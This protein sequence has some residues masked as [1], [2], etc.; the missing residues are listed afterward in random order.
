MSVRGDWHA[1]P[2]AD[3]VARLGSDTALGLSGQEARRRLVTYG[4]NTLPVPAGAS[5][6][7]RLWSQ[8]NDFLIL[9]LAVAAS[10]SA[11]VG[12]PV[13]A[14]VILG[15][16]VIN[17]AL[18]LYQESKA[19]HALAHLQDLAPPVA[20][21][22]RNGELQEIAAASLVPG[23]LVLV[24]SGD[25]VPADLR[26]IET[27]NL[28]VNEAPL[29]GEAMAVEK[30]AEALP[31]LAAPLGE[32]VNMAYMGTTVVY[33]RGRGVVVSTGQQS[34]IGTITSQLAEG[35]L[36]RTHLQ[37]KLAELGHWLG[38]VTLAV[39]GVVFIAGVFQHRPLLH[40]FLTAVSL[41]VAA[42]PEG[43]PAVITV[44][45]AIG[46]QRMAA[47]HAV[48][49]R[50]GA[51]EA[52]GAVTLIASDKTG[53]LTENTMAAVRLWLPGRVVE[54]PAG[55]NSQGSLDG[56]IDTTTDPRVGW[57]IQAGVLCNDA[58]PGTAG[59][60]GLSGVDHRLV[61]GDP[62]EVGLVRLGMAAGL[63]IDYVRR[64][65]PRRGE[66]PFSPE[67]R[68]MVTVH[69]WG[70]S[71]R[72]FVKGAPEVVSALCGRIM[73]LAGPV[74][75]TPDWQRRVEEANDA[76]ASAAFRVL[77]V[78]FRDMPRGLGDPDRWEHDLVFLGL[79]A[80]WDPVRP[81]VP[82]ALARAEA[83]GIRTVMITGDN[84][85]TA[86]AV[87]R[88][89]GMLPAG[90]AGSMVVSG[91]EIDLQSDLELQKVARTAR[92]YARVMPEHKLRIV[93]ALQQNGHLV[94]VTGDGVNDVLALQRAD[95]SVAMG[96]TGTDVARG[97]ADMVLTDDNYASIVA[98]IEEG[99]LIYAN[100]RKF[101]Y[102]LLSCNV[103]EVLMVFAAMLLGLPVPLEP[104]H[105][106]WVNLLTDSF[107][108]LA[109][110]LE[111]GE[112]Q[113]MRAPPRDP[114]ENIITR[115]MQRGI[116][117]QSVAVAV[118]A[119]LGMVWALAGGG[120]LTYARTVTLTTVTVAEL[121]RAFTARTE[122]TPVWKLG[123]LSNPA[124]IIAVAL[125]GLLLAAVLYVP[126][127]RPVFHT[128]PLD[129]TAWKMALG[130]GLLPALVAE[131]GKAYHRQEQ[132]RTRS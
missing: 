79:V 73:T 125:S 87:A 55:L 98:A 58:Q 61:L 52:L 90:P 118:A 69:A 116:A 126:A 56:V 33:G 46:T 28:R 62:T 127:L 99:R 49:R 129:W 63:D 91:P 8:L 83:A 111:Q 93:K 101:V 20:R 78:G 74:S 77:A 44:A 42:I 110:G 106:L 22:V 2:L 92:V 117:I 105:L 47:R 131:A 51:V 59:K 123:L 100:I 29:T 121:L 3:V 71:D 24:S 75:F 94:A 18:G 12:Q 17:A 19:E 89:L 104:V 97:V 26:L 14:A 132:A 60:D 86:A 41:A 35:A 5:F 107:P 76:M 96:V 109:L 114:R 112:T 6:L 102:F 45:L 25:S 54:I 70:E 11:L 15:I 10:V 113:L 80:L 37:E 50:L 67:R 85:H 65:H 36:A 16:V 64:A 1:L 68:R 119:L 23:D 32:R 13:D 21:V 88:A 66:I 108:A 38:T 34:V 81:E 27:V 4:E 72:V 40:M 82:P 7:T 115:R 128:V 103:G 9:I 122:T 95:V 120:G 124:L 53:T 30:N 31:S 39:C 57:L 130:L 84:P 48:I 43:L